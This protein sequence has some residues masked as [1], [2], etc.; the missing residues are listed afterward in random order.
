MKMRQAFSMMLVVLTLMV[1]AS[2]GQES[3]T[4]GD[5]VAWERYCSIYAATAG[6]PSGGAGVNRAA[7]CL[8]ALSDIEAAIESGWSKDCATQWHKDDLNGKWPDPYRCE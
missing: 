4:E 8:R 5:R 3:L 2:C 7:E 6:Q 1:A